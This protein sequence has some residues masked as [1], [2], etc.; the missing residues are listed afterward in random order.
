MADVGTISV[1]NN[2]PPDG[3]QVN[4]RYDQVLRAGD[5]LRAT[6]YLSNIETQFLYTRPQFNHPYPFKNQLLNLAHTWVLSN[7]TLN[8]A[9]FGYV[10]QHGEAADTTPES[11]NVGPGNVVAGFGVEF[12]HPIDFTQH[13]WQVKD[14][15]KSC[16]LG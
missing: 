6:Y 15:L 14:T 2:G 7:Q 16:R 10:R 12:W 13:N 3:D 11:P 5:R 1:V 9:T 8:E 4:F